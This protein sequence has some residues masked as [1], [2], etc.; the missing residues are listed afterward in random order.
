MPSIRQFHPE[1]AVEAIDVP[2]C[3][4]YNWEYAS[5]RQRLVF[6]F[7]HQAKDLKLLFGA[8][9]ARQVGLGSLLK[10]VK[11]GR[12]NQGWRKRDFC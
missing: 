11:A 4:T 5:P 2:Q 9:A 6:L 1:A 12:A 7:H 3:L 10:R 8:A